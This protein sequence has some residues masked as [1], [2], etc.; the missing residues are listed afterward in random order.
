MAHK[1]PITHLLFIM[2]TGN[3]LNVS[4]LQKLWLKDYKEEYALIV[5]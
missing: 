3:Y 1:H 2:R 5:I 4:K